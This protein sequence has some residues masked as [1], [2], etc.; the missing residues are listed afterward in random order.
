MDATIFLSD[1]GNLEK[2]VLFRWSMSYPI[3]EHETLTN[4]L[5]PVI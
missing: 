5:G 4:L 2:M 1:E 3:I